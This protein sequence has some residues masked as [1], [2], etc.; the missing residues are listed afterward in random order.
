MIVISIVFLA[1]LLM[2][3]M[4]SRLSPKRR[5]N[6]S[7]FAVDKF[8]LISIRNV[9]MSKLMVRPRF[10]RHFIVLEADFA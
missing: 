1:I 7:F 6:D 3:K 10:I 8:G 9:M 4:S 5:S 2:I